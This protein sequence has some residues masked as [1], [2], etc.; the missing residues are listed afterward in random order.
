MR[1]VLVTSDS[2]AEELKMSTM[3]VHHVLITR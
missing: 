2:I 1:G 3:L